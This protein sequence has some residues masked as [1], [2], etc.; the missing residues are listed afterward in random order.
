M[1]IA[2]SVRYFAQDARES[3]KVQVRLDFLIRI[4]KSGLELFVLLMIFNTY[5][6]NKYFLFGWYL[7][8][9]K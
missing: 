7:K 8:G 2:F 1:G 9:L 4:I 6:L 5:L 3:E